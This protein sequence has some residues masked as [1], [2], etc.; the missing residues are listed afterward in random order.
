MN[1]ASFSFNEQSSGP[2]ALGAWLRWTP[3]MILLLT[4]LILLMLWNQIPDRW[5]VHWGL[6]GQP[7]HWTDKTLPGVFFP[8]GLG[9]GVCLFFELLAFIIVRNLRQRKSEKISPE[10]ARAIAERMVEFL[11]L[12]A[13]AVAVVLSALSIILPLLQPSRPFGFVLFTFGVLILAVVTGIWRVVKL[14][15]ELKARGKFAGL[16]GWNGLTYRNPNDP[17]LWVPKITGVGYTLN[18]AHRRARPLVILFIS[19][20]LIIVAVIALLLRSS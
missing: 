16:E 13:I 18:F 4:A 11:R 14:Q 17:R 15:R 2:R 12:I 20:P 9:L 19:L 8:L 3:F 7:D 5:P 6:N 10:A 1:S